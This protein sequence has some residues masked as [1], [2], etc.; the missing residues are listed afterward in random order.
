MFKPMLAATI[1]DISTLQYPLLASPKLDGIRATVH[2]T[3]LLTRSLKLVPNIHCQNKFGSLEFEGLDGELIVGEPTAKDCFRVTTSGVMAVQGTPDVKFY[4]FDRVQE[5]TTFSQRMPTLSTSTKKSIVRVPQVVIHTPFAL[6]EYEESMLERGFEGV[7]LR[8]PNGLYKFGRSTVREG[9]LMKL[10]RFEDGEAVVE[11][12]TEL[13]NNENEKTLESVGKAKRSSK[14]EGMVGA[15][16]L[17]ALVVRDI[18]TGAQFGIGS[19]FTAAERAALW[20]RR[21]LEGKI[22]K[23]KFF[24]SGSKDAP[25][26]PV[27]IGFRDEEDMS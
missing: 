24:P 15:R 16:T 11:G 13:H 20:G 9:G 8:D 19:G 5:L 12:V 7:M 6:H 17:G 14:K 25:R 26:F 4:V 23:Y 1:T 27:F 22:V 10:K 2:R 3:K 18:A 21:D